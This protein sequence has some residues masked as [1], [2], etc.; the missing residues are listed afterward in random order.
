MRLVTA[1]GAALLATLGAALLATALATTAEA[2]PCKAPKQL[3]VQWAA[4]GTG[5]IYVI[6]H[7]CA[8][9]ASCPVQA[10]TT[11]TKLP[12]HVALRSGGSTVFETDMRACAD[13]RIC[14]SVNT[15]GCN[16]GGDAH[17][18]ATDLFK[19]SFLHKDM[20]SL[21]LRVRGA[22]SRPSQ[23]SGPFTLDVADA[24]GYS[25]QATFSKCRSSDRPTGVTIICR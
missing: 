2:A 24:A 14:G 13:T 3:K 22:M 17:K 7:A 5:Q 9:P 20:A 4:A 8:L 25:A 1:L 15:S 6:A 19:L 23:T 21:M 12:L 18:T 11:A 16:G 10:G